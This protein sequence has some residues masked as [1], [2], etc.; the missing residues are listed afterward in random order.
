MLTFAQPAK[1]QVDV[2]ASSNC[3]ASPNRSGAQGQDLKGELSAFINRETVAGRSCP[4]RACRGS[5]EG[6]ED[7]LQIQIVIFLDRE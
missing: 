3:N 4:K 6:Q 7:C 2:A 5:V 1:R